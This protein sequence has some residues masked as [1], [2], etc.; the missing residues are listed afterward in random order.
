[1]HSNMYESYISLLDQFVVAI[2]DGFSVPVATWNELGSVN[3]F[4]YQLGIVFCSGTRSWNWKI[5]TGK[6]VLEL[7]NRFDLVPRW[8]WS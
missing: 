7:E 6:P 3:Q 5:G 8:Y 4:K 2:S 1:M